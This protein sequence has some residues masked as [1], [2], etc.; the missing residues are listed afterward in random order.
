MNNR[1]HITRLIGGSDKENL[2]RCEKAL[3]EIA[4]EFGASGLF[5]SP[6]M[7]VVIVKIGTA[8]LLEAVKAHKAV[9]RETEK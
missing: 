8:E 6:A 1:N 2:E 3:E 7:V 5:L 4:E 9:S